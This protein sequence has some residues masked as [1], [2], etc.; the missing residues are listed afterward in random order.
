MIKKVIRFG[1]IGAALAIVV[2]GV[3]FFLR[4]SKYSKIDSITLIEERAV[5][6]VKYSKYKGG[7]LKSGR[8]GA[9]YLD[10]EGNLIWT[11]AFLINN[12]KVAIS[13]DRVAVADIKGNN[14]YIF[15]EKGKTSDLSTPYTI[16]DL[17]ISQNG[18]VAVTMEDKLYNYVFIYDSMGGIIAESKTSMERDGI[19]LSVT[20]SDDGTK[21]VTSYLHTD[22]TNI[23]SRVTFY[24]FDEVGKNFS[25]RFLGSFTNEGVII[26]KIDFINN[27]TL[28]AFSDSK[29]IIYDA[30]YIPKATKEIEVLEQI[31][32][33]FANEGYF[34]IVKEMPINNKKYHVDVF[35]S[36]G[37]P[38][39]GFGTNLDY[40]ELILNDEEI[41]ISN[42]FRW[43]IY[44]LKGKLKYEGSF[45]SSVE[46]VLPI[47]KARYILVSTNKVEEIK[48]K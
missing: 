3:M 4:N 6:Q 25:D 37:K 46:K 11:Q 48:L 44:N 41:I 19:P 24:R 18:V 14:V 1:I 10:K 29:I 5:G 26:P 13:G 38:E 30:S 34:G 23:S 17:A 28:I 43:E 15:N 31:A 7:I 16:I 33:V 9:Q 22:G 40:K 8:D 35:D 12:P 27:D 45:D 2:I 36:S 21:L 32:G 42:G 47:K 39:G 20:I